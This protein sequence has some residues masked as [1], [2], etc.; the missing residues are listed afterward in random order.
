MSLV[1]GDRGGKARPSAEG[2]V[3]VEGDELPAAIAGILVDQVPVVAV[4]HTKAWFRLSPVEEP[5]RHRQVQELNQHQQTALHPAELTIHL[6]DRTSI[7][8]EQYR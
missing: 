2:E 3:H 7:S 5:S 1:T 6:M 8:A 4:P